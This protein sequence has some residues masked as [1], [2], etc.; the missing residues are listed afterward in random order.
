VT[1]IKQK[2][3]LV[4]DRPENL[5][6]L[7]ALFEG[8]DLD[9]IKATSGMQAL[10]LVLE[11]DFALI[12]MDVQMPEMDGFETAELMRGTKRSK[13]IPIIFVT[14][15]N[16]EDRHVFKGYESGAVDY[17]FKPVNPEIIKSKVKV[18]L[19]LDRQKKML[20]KQATD[21]EKAIVRANEMAAQSDM[22]N[23]AKGEFLSNMSH[24]IRTPLNAVIGMTGL[25][26]E[27]DMTAE[28][29]DYA[30][31]VRTSSDAL[32]R[33]INDIL[34][35]SKVEAGKLDLEAI[36][37][38]LRTTLENVGDML[39]PK[40]YKNGLEFVSMFH[41]EVPA[42]LR[43]D[44]GRLRQ[45]LINLAGN[46]VKFTKQGE[47][48][49]RAIL[50]SETATRA[51]IRF[52]V[53]DTGIGIPKERQAHI[54]ES[55][56][57]VDAS[58]T[59]KYGGTGLGLAISKKLVE[60]M[61]GQIGLES[62]TE[63]GSTF[64][65]TAIFEK[66]PDG[67]EAPLILP[68]DICGKRILVIDDNATSLKFLCASL[69]SWGCQYHSATD[70]E[71]GLSLLHQSLKSATPFHLVLTDHMM[72]GMDGEALGHAIK[73]DP[74]LKETALVML[75]SGGK[76]GDAA[77]MKAIGFDAYLTKPVKYRQL[78]DC[79]TTVLGKAA[80]ADKNEPKRTLVTRHTIAEAMPKLR[81][82]VAE[83]NIVNQKLV[84][85]L[86]EKKGFRTDVVS[87]GKEAVKAMT[88]IPYDLVLMDVQM[89]EM[90]GLEAAKAIRDP[91][92]KTL[93]PEVPIIAVTANAMKG[94]QERCFAAG[95][96]DY[97]SKPINPQEM[98]DK[99]DTWIEATNNSQASVSA[100]LG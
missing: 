42:R 89:P 68:A 88:T 57:Q 30:E 14:A 25:L 91:Q 93:R 92:N 62:E 73:T 37:F 64:W 97:L 7:E 21:L 71:E 58:T 35:F 4:D 81:I 69:K 34:D 61:G 28:Q 24:E 76:R 36:D 46:A 79:L 41:P 52:E 95:M 55:F 70:P 12:L 15:I 74:L 82:L 51:T 87:N 27:T 85:R 56:S 20:E 43:G 45:I 86:L 38:D 22:A 83:D 3:L 19:D 13:H 9:I 5:V 50:D 72:P 59:R 49:V 75:T 8:D 66:Q 67:Q 1:P 63:K 84:L 39:A 32:L 98:F 90:D 48:A 29:R 33:L 6:A 2:I 99:I 47:V 26:L 53:M 44:P 65:F 60:M 54:F 100:Q 18:F 77:R 10:G 78:F 17:L 11:H 23:K 31:T 16:K 96:Q 94:D 40:A 80:A